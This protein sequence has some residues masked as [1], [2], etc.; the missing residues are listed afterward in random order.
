MDQFALSV[1]LGGLLL[2]AALFPLH[3]WLPPAHSSAPAPVSA[4]LSALVVKGSYYLILR[5]W[6]D[7]AAAW[8]S[9]WLAFG[10]GSLGLAAIL[11]GCVQA[12]R[13]PRLKLLVAYSTVAQLGYLFLLFP[14]VAAGGGLG[15]WAGGIY[16]AVSHAFAKTAIFMAAGNIMHSAGH[17]RLAELG[18]IARVMPVTFFALALAGLNA[19]GLPPSGGF[20]GKWLLLNQALDSGQWVFVLVIG[21]G[22]LL[23][24]AYIVRV[25]N[26][27]LLRPRHDP[28]R[29]E[30]PHFHRLPAV[31]EW[32][33]LVLALAAILL[34]LFVAAPMRL[35]E[36][37]APVEGVWLR[38]GGR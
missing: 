4:A 37:G 25:L 29:A 22:G 3:F 16:F 27:A 35:L 30:H 7:L 24:A 9:P 13:Q 31:M 23:A 12:L 17:D 11:W 15:A 21:F 18:G 1:M 38:G 19:I 8:A 34:G 26:L 2:K 28:H 20:I 10:L 36:Q 5:L 33:P 32:T 14:L 6:F